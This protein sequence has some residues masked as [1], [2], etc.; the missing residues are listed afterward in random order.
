MKYKLCGKE[1]MKWEKQY[2][3]V[4][5][6]YPQGICSKMPS[7]CLKLW[8]A[9]EYHDSTSDSQDG[10]SVPKWVGGT[11]SM[12]VWDKGMTHILSRMV[13]DRARF[14]HTAQKSVQFKTYEFFISGIFHLIF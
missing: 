10:H 6:P 2:I 11:C 12:D 13:W 9:L 4:V 1:R 7:G 5:S 3:A 14:H 8:V